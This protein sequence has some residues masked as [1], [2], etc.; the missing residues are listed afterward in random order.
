MAKIK[1]SIKVKIYELLIILLVLLAVTLIS[2]ESFAADKVIRQMAAIQRTVDMEIA[3]KIFS[4]CIKYNIPCEIYV[5]IIAQESMFKVN[6]FNKKTQDYGIAQINIRN[7]KAYN[8]DVKKLLSDVDYSLEQGAMILAWFYKVYGKKEPK[9]WYC[10]YNIG[11]STLTDKRL[12]SCN[13]Y[14]NK[15]NKYVI[16]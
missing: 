10:R 8:I 2:L 14:L 4:K 15:V 16:N 1:H 13:N 7:I 6:A 11:T 12:Q 5:A 3:K 9:T